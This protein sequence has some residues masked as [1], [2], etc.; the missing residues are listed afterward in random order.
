MRKANPN[1]KNFPKPLYT[2]V[3]QHK[4]AHIAK[5]EALLRVYMYLSKERETGFLALSSFFFSFFPVYAHARMHIK[6]ARASRLRETR[7]SGPI[8]N[9]NPRNKLHFEMRL[10]CTYMDL[11][12]CDR[13][14]IYC[15]DFILGAPMRVMNKFVV[16]YCSRTIYSKSVFIFWD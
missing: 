5:G 9:E 2:G 1:R 12:I 11:Y 4:F 15:K 7:C 14:C 6:R 13:V 8:L 3:V 10:L 16:N